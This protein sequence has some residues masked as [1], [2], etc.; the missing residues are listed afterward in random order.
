[1]TQ[2]EFRMNL[3]DLETYVIRCMGFADLVDF[4][5]EIKQVA[6]NVKKYKEENYLEII[7]RGRKKLKRLIS[8]ET[9]EQ[10]FV[11]RPLDFSKNK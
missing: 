6:E 7:S 9:Y 5:T 1:M 2:H 11:V 3:V 10:M 4:R 8:E